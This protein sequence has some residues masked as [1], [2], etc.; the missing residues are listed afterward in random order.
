MSTEAPPR[1][2]SR[3]LQLQQQLLQLCCVESRNT[4]HQSSQLTTPAAAVPGPRQS[5]RL[6]P[7]SESV[8]PRLALAVSLRWQA[9]GSLS[10]TAGHWHTGRGPR[11]AVTRDSMSRRCGLPARGWRC[12][13]AARAA[14]NLTQSPGPGPPRPRRHACRPRQRYGTK[15]RS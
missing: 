4:V 3:N 2:N 8:W 10:G 11:R 1:V 15:L 14:S 6:S 13:L 9:D 5:L 12:Q 7:N